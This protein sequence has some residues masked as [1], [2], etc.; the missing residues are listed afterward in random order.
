LQK[1]K[2][3]HQVEGTDTSKKSDPKTFVFRRGKHWVSFTHSNSSSRSS[4]HR[5]LS[6]V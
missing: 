2:R 4:S 1:K 6:K 5:L 3:T